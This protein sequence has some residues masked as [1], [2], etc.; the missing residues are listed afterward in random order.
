VPTAKKV[1]I[2]SQKEHQK[3]KTA[4]SSK[5][6]RGSRLPTHT[7]PNIDDNPVTGD[8]ETTFSSLLHHGIELTLALKK[9][10]GAE[11]SIHISWLYGL[12]GCFEVNLKSS[13]E[14]FEREGG[15]QIAQVLPTKTTRKDYCDA[16][17]DYALR[18]KQ[19]SECA[20]Q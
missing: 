12:F 2:E 10:S 11:F 13:S 8:L 16:E 5:S 19:S 15:C 14:I 6:V 18:R 17:Q 1:S 4:A 9:E 7:H 20:G 3:K